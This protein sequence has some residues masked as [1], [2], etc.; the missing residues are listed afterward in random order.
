MYESMQVRKYGCMVVLIYGCMDVV[1]S[2]FLS[3]CK[4]G[5]R[6]HVICNAMQRNATQCNGLS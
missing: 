4:F 1:L 2:V 3:L 5:Y 6:M